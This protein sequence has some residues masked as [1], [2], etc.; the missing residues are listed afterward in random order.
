[1]ALLLHVV[2]LDL[3]MLQ[4]VLGDAWGHGGWRQGDG[5]LAADV[6]VTPLMQ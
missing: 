6:A 5:H 2:M 3:A 4:A 1:M